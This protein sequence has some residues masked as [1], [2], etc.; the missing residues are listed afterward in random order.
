MPKE[1]MIGV[2]A[3]FVGA[4]S[5]LA[6]S[7][8]AVP[9]LAQVST[10][11]TSIQKLGNGEIDLRLSPPGTYRVHVS[12]N[13]PHWEPLLTAPSQSNAYVDG[14]A[15]YLTNRFYRLQQVT[16]T[17]VLTGDHIATTN[18]DVIIHPVTHA[19][20]VMRWNDVMIYNDPDS[21]GAL[22]SSFPRADLVL[23]SH[24]HS[25]HFDAPTIAAV[26]AT[27]GIIIAPQA[28]FNG[29]NTTLRAATI[30][31]DNGES[32]NVNGVH[33]EA[34]PSYNSNH[35]IG[36]GNG[37]VVTIGGKRFYMA[38]DTGDI[39]EMRAL[40]NIDVAF[41][42]MNVPFTMNVTTAASV[43][44]AFRPRILYPYHYRNQDNTLANFTDLKR[45]IGTE[46]GIEVR[47][48]K[49]Y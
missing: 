25:D 14:G 34:I 24:S 20:F 16:E 17:N 8:C 32:T 5:L 46:H 49:W 33:I 37:Y 40:Q 22:Y 19:S 30:V 42:C 47:V 10:S 23:V 31:L 18:G 38:G 21:G 15:V 28:V 9:V 39:P 2:R 35:P 4:I 43:A 27:N 29:L 26:R 6:A 41:L 13:L 7:F 11:F 45:L 48:R 3:F 1:I 44:R 12:T 36:T